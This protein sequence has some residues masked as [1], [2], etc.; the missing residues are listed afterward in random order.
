MN[1]NI[2][3]DDQ[4]GFRPKRPITA[5]NYLFLFEAFQKYSQK[6]CYADF[7][8]AFDSVNLKVLINSNGFGEP[9]FLCSLSSPPLVTDIKRAK[10]FDGKCFV[11]FYTYSC[12]LQTA[13][14]H[15]FHSFCLPIEYVELCLIAVHLVLHVIWKYLRKLILLIAAC[16][17]FAKRYCFVSCLDGVYFTYITTVI[18]DAKDFCSFS[19]NFS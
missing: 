2:R 18:H 14:F 19:S 12:L 8:K 16:L 5:F 7:V 4:H 3:I 17:V 9:F 6:W 1:N 11:L 15:I 13:T 10:S